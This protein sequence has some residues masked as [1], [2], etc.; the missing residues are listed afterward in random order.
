MVLMFV[1]GTF[2]AHS[3][4]GFIILGVCV[5]VFQGSIHGISTIYLY[6]KLMVAALWWESNSICWVHKCS[7]DWTSSH[8][9][10]TF[11]QTR[12]N[13]TQSSSNTSKTHNIAYKAS[14]HSTTSMWTKKPSLNPPK[15]HPTLWEAISNVSMIASELA[16]TVTTELSDGRRGLVSPTRRGWFLSQWEVVIVFFFFVVVVVGCSCFE[17][18]CVSL[19][20]LLGYLFCG[21]KF[22]VMCGSACFFFRW[23]TV[24][25]V[26]CSVQNRLGLT[27]I[28]RDHFQR[29]FGVRTAIKWPYPYH[30]CMVYL[31]TFG[32]L[33]WQ[34][35]VNVGK[36]ALHGC[37]GIYDHDSKIIDTLNMTES[38]T[39]HQS[40]SIREASHTCW[41]TVPPFMEII[42]SLKGLLV[43]LLM[44]EILHHLGCIK[45][46]K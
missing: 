42:C 18:I 7:I 28:S 4:S 17:F 26:R 8:T 25:F 40:S 6:V 15:A 3:G 32:C 46:C 19:R 10:T 5:F 43:V 1:V 24:H 34:N 29:P 11:I 31:P 2:L 21:E 33:Q 12:S 41:S 27:S 38:W 14:I 30:P 45:P 35:M 16:G 9:P 20:L 13:P 44:E 36:Y 23:K 22:I 37:Y 39:C